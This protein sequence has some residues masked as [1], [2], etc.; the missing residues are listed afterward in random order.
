MRASE[1]RFIYNIKFDRQP[2]IN[3][4]D[5]QKKKKDNEIG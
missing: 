4:G 5:Q 1:I 2:E 3:Q